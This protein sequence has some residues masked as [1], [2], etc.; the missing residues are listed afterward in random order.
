V[1]ILLLPPSWEEMERRLRG[2]GLDAPE[3]VRRRLAR[4]R[5]EIESYDTYDYVVVNREL[6]ATCAMVE[7]I[8]R[9]E[10][11]RRSG[12]PLSSPGLQESS[13]QA[14]SARME[15][16]RSRISAILDTFGAKAP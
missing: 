4:A 15:V 12:Q 11:A 13:R 14:D 5:Q 2:R 1:A 6:L 8:V 7:A 9:T 3:V 10:R 16:N